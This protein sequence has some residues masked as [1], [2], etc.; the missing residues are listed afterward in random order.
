MDNRKFDETRE[1][2]PLSD[3]SSRSSE[4]LPKV[5]RPV[6]AAPAEAPMS[7][8]KNSVNDA[9]TAYFVPPK[10]ADAELGVERTAVGAAPS[11]AQPNPAQQKRAESP[12]AGKRP[13]VNN[14]ATKMISS[15]AVKAETANKK[16]VRRPRQK[17]EIS[18]AGN[19]LI[20][21]LKCM[22]YITAVFVVSVII[23]VTVIFLANDIYG[24]VKSEDQIEVTIPQNAT[25]EEVADILHEN[26]IIKYKWLF[27]MKE[28]GFSGKFAEGIYTLTPKSSYDDLIEAIREKPPAGISWVTIPEGFTTDEIIDLLVSHGIGKKDR[29]VEVINSYD[30]DYWFVDA[31]G[32]DW[33]KDG[34]I[35]RLDGYLFPDTYQ[36]Y[37]ASSEEAVIS[38]LLARF[39]QVFVKGYEERAAELGYTVDEILIIA[40]L[41]EK[42]AGT[43]ADF[44]NVSSV[45]HNRL[46]KPAEYPYLESDATVAYAL[47]HETGVRVKVT[48]D[49]LDFYKSPYNSYLERGLV[50]GPIANPSNSAILAALNPSETGYYFFV[51]SDDVTYF[52]TNIYEHNAKIEQIRR[53]NEQKAQAAG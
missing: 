37:N 24:F 6:N 45:F 52:S 33:D 44:G 38:K 14:N 17:S 25:V 48:A 34:R 12:A 41:I 29:Y 35:Y 47:H 5:S 32:E 26:G 8:A 23:S 42:E 49:D 31:L 40:S 28:D 36:F 51:A 20:S 22:A 7:A 19:T 21:L 4:S 1:N 46:K 27:K 39:N 43:A 10:S 9:R 30:F 15:D 53:E 18:E 50:P 16:K 11:A 3:V 13:A 2:I